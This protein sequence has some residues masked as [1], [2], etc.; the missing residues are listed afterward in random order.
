MIFKK[1]LYNLLAYLLPFVYA[2][3]VVIS[4]TTIQ[5][6]PPHKKKRPSGSEM[7]HLL[8]A[9]RANKTIPSINIA[10]VRLR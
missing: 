10:A 7:P 2:K 6:I 8:I 1:T 9:A 4:E 5:V 3:H